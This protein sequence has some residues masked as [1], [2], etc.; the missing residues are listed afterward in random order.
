MFDLAL[1]IVAS[2][3]TS[4]IRS[5]SLK[6][7]SQLISCFARADAAKTLARLFPVCDRH[8]RIEIEGGAS[9]TRTTSTHTPIESD[10]TLQWWIGLLSGAVTNAGEHV[11][12]SRICFKNRRA[13]H[14]KLT[15]AQVQDSNFVVAQIHDRA[16]QI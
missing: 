7:V 9:S 16:L 3:A 2:H 13:D 14:H 4:S 6:V 8:I 5:N 1:D 15:G 11:R 10:V 12:F